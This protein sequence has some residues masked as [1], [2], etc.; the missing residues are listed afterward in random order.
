MS[1]TTGNLSQGIEMDGS[2]TPDIVPVCTE[3]IFL[4]KNYSFMIT[5]NNFR[6]HHW[7]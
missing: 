2:P 1:D 7:T 4:M 6:L 3:L 5:T